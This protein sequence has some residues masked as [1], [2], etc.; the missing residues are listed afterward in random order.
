MVT[1]RER[2]TDDTDRADSEFQLLHP[3]EDEKELELR[4]RLSEENLNTQLR[5]RLPTTPSSFRRTSILS[6]EIV[7][8][9]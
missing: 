6:V 4:F 8:A 7:A 3:S 1:G 2:R 9:D 5:T